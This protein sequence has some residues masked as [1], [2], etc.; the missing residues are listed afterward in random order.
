[1]ERVLAIFSSKV[2]HAAFR[3]VDFG[4]TESI[5]GHVFSGH[6]LDNLGAG[7]EHVGNAFGHYSEVGE[8]GRIYRATGTWT[9]DT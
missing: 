5:L 8:C 7:E 2:C 6:S 1:V 9:E 4:A 3:R